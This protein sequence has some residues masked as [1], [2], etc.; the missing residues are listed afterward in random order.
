M[1]YLNKLFLLLNVNFLRNSSMENINLN[2]QME[3]ISEYEELK[4][5]NYYLIISEL[6]DLQKLF[7]EK[8]NDKNQEINNIT[9]DSIMLQLT[10]LINLELTD[11]QNE[12]INNISQDITQNSIISELRDF[13]NLLDTKIYNINYSEKKELLLDKI[14]KNLINIFL[15]LQTINYHNYIERTEF[16]LNKEKIYQSYKY[17]ILSKL[18]QLITSELID[19]KKLLNEK[20]NH[21]NHS[22]KKEILINK[23]NKNLID[24]YFYFKKTMNDENYEKELKEASNEVY[25]VVIKYEE[26]FN[27]VL[28]E[29]YKDLIVIE[30]TDLQKLFHE[31][32]NNK[33]NIEEKKEILLNKVNEEKYPNILSNLKNL[34]I[35]LEELNSN[36][37]DYN[38]SFKESIMK[39]IFKLIFVV[40]KDYSFLKETEKLEEKIKIFKQKANRL[41]YIE[42]ETKDMSFNEN[43]NN[44]KPF[45]FPILFNKYLENP[46]PSFYQNVESIIL[47][48]ILDKIKQIIFYKPYDNINNY[49]LC[50]SQLE[51]LIKNTNTLQ[52]NS[53]IFQIFNEEFIKIPNEKIEDENNTA[54]DHMD[55]QSRINETNMVLNNMKIQ[56]KMLDLFLDSLYGETG[57]VSKETDNFRLLIENMNYL[58]ENKTFEKLSKILNKSTYESILKEKNLNK[59][60][61]NI[62]LLEENNILEILDNILNKNFKKKLYELLINKLPSDASLEFLNIIISNIKLLEENYILYKILNEDFK[63]GIY[64]LIIDK[65]HE[66]RMKKILENIEFLFLKKQKSSEDKN[67]FEILDKILNEDFKK[68]IY[69]VIITKLSFFY[70]TDSFVTIFNKILSNIGSL[71]EK[72]IFNILDN[73]LNK[74]FKNQ[75]CELII[76]E[77]NRDDFIIS[78]KKNLSICLNIA[79]NSIKSLEE[80]NIFGILDNILNEDFKK[81]IYE[82]IINEL[83]EKFR[84]QEKM[85][86][87]T[88]N[89]KLLKDNEIFKILNEDILNENF[90]KE[91]YILIIDELHEEEKI[92]NITNNL[93]F[94]EKNNIF[95]ILNAFKML[96]ED[97]LNEDFKKQI[98]KLIIYGVNEEETKIK[99]II[100]N[101]QFLEKNN[102]FEILNA[103]KMLNEDILNEDFKKQI[104]NLII[105]KLGDKK[106][107]NYIINNIKFLENNEIFKILNEDILNE[108]FKKE[109]YKLI[110]YGVNE[111]ETKI[112]N[113]IN[114]LQFLKGNNIFKI[115][116]NQ[117][118]GNNTF[119]QIKNDLDEN[120]EDFKEEYLKLKYSLDK[121]EKEFK[122]EDSTV[123]YSLDEIE[124]KFKSL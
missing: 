62:K 42:E 44:I 46:N 54:V 7:N 75:I 124:N 108:N 36:I 100:N 98:Y 88:N 117:P 45:L 11:L 66:E 15:N 33:H 113:I 70:S 73:I 107:M 89:I 76:D 52:N 28:N 57:E 96:N 34:T 61:N 64:E 85:K 18:R 23:V 69:K 14:T 104:Y 22:E 84:T 74:D 79:L 12:K 55:I 41:K 83:R 47:N 99:N 6:R 87:I 115:L 24:I 102:I 25:K 30:L 114:N 16:L 53:N 63:E 26:K 121:N 93:Q 122:E 29:V 123:D 106:Q 118:N 80:N 40:E 8:I 4:N 95:E 111:E 3:P 65:L 49:M 101:L 48:K 120:E 103:F 17:R 94:L 56:Y 67:I 10:D 19:F 51:I 35:I 39:E 77:L 38:N 116:E 43:I 92:K 97:I 60:I 32:T 110:I 37:F 112:K 68:S 21:I 109:I 119:I 20:I 13:I 2:F 5:K 9:Q 50:K 86:N 59:I 91:I 71:K 31:K 81:G 72:N 78:E 27:K 105:F 1:Q 82:L 90:K 58:Q